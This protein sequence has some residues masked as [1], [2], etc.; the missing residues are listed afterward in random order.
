MFDIEIKI[1]LSDTE[2]T[3][4]H[5]ENIKRKDLV[6][7]INQETNKLKDKKVEEI[8]IRRIK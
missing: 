6:K 1:R 2:I 3:T 7:V 5:K 4:E 8:K